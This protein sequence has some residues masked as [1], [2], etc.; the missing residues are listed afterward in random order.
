MRR[1]AVAYA[2]IACL[3]G[4]K[5]WGQDSSPWLAEHRTVPNFAVALIVIFGILRGNF[6]TKRYLRLPSTEWFLTVAVYAYALV[7]LTWTPDFAIALDQW[8]LQAPYI[9]LVAFLAPFLVTSAADIRH[10]CDWTLAVG[11]TLCALALFAGHWGDRGLLV[12]GDVFDQETNP[13]ALA[14]LAGTVCVISLVSLAS[15]LPRLKKLL[16]VIVVPIAIAVLLRS[17]SRGQ[18]AASAIAVVIG[19]PLAA[20]ERR[21]GTWALIVVAGFL[22]SIL[23]WWIWSQLNIDSVRWTSVQFSEDAANRLAMAMHLLSYTTASTVTVFLGLG[24]SSSFHFLGI[25]PHV[26]GLEVLAEEGLIGTCI[27]GALLVIATRSAL[28][29]IGFAQRTKDTEMIYASAVLTALFVFQ[30]LLSFKQGTLLSSVNVFSYAAILGR[31]YLRRSIVI[32]SQVR[33]DER[34]PYPN[35]LR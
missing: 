6:S 18:L 25:Y 7:S 23:G 19:L 21:F 26:T 32:D 20:R 31:L 11:G 10:I 4:L 27:Y 33:G 2:A 29:L 5:Q 9:V 34:E 17:G 8:K 30:L 35:L 15:S 12:A 16:Y 28:R 3:Y 1:P 14:S 22:V 24:N 13:L